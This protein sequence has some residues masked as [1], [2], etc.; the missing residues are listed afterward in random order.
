MKRLPLKI[1]V[2]LLITYLTTSLFFYLFLK[3]GYLEIRLIDFKK[4]IFFSI[5]VMLTESLTV[6]YK[7]MSFSTSFAITL[8]SY[9]LFGAFNAI[10]IKI[11][12]FTF[13]VAKGEKKKYSH[14]L[15]TPFYG[16]LSNYCF[17]I[18]PLLVGNYFYIT[19]GGSFGGVFLLKNI[20]YI[21]F[22]S[23]ILFLTNTLLISILSSLMSGKNFVYWFF[24]NARIMILNIV[25]MIPF[26][27]IIVVVFNEYNY[28][29]VML[30]FFPTVLARYTYSLFLETK[31][32]YIQL[33]NALT[34]SL[35]AR[36]QYTEGHS[37]RV[38]DI[39][40]M[41]AK[42]LKYTEWKIEELRVASLLHDVGK[43]GVS[44]NILLKPGK[45]ED[46]EFAI[47]KA[48][49]EIGYT[50]LKDVKNLSKITT[51]VRYHHERYDGKG[52]PVGKSHD[53]LE[54]DVFIVQLADAIDAMATDRPYRKALPEER[55]IEEIKNNSGT[56]FHPMVVK[57][58]L[59]AINKKIN[60]KVL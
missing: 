23:L 33:V 9:I 18:L 60:K 16:T 41:I 17:L 59:S 26:A 7:K 37:Q 58:Y 54:L 39:V 27:L 44:D 6:V 43:I 22:F 8:S 57:A 46:D 5:L 21:M 35:E 38:A 31:E 25:A 52:Y 56:Q 12:G 24:N 2:F 32:Q 55:I 40:T 34:R 50:I 11:I 29:G 15:N 4:I 14:I 1:K 53:Q 10:I 47:I 45:L 28:I 19:L 13:R 51:I 20:V 42:E 48:H 3:T 30:M 49:P 36:D